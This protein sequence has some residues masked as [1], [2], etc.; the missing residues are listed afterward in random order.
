MS[1][2]LEFAFDIF[3]GLFKAL[4]TIVEP[5]VQVGEGA[6]DLIGMFV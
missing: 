5:L 4:Y 6:S 3:G 1:S 2:T